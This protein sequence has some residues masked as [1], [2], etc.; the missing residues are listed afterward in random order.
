MLP[1]TESLVNCSW[2]THVV[3][4]GEKYAVQQMV[5]HNLVRG[6]ECSGSQPCPRLADKRRKTN[7]PRPWRVHL[8]LHHVVCIEKNRSGSGRHARLAELGLVDAAVVLSWRALLCLLRNAAGSAASLPCFSTFA[9]E[10]MADLRWRG[11][12]QASSASEPPQRLGPDSAFQCRPS[13]RERRLVPW[14]VP[15]Q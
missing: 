5:K 8:C 14:F 12:T 15:R 3:R 2:Q 4:A 1:C 11:W 6:Q 10:D 13:Q 7:H 9:S